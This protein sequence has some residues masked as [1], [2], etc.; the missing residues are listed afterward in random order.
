MREEMGYD[1]L[2]ITDALNMNAISDHFGSVDA[3]IRAVKAG[4]DIVLMPV[5]LKEV[6][7]GLLDAVKSGEISENAW[8]HLLS[9]F[10][11]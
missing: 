4:T 8:K 5:G 2:I 6:A 3:A 10:W 1:G 9:G 7:D 11:L